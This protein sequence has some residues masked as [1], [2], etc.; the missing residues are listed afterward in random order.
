MR[1]LKTMKKNTK[2]TTKGH[3][4]PFVNMLM[5]ML[6]LNVM[7]KNTKSTT[8]FLKKENNRNIM[9]YEHGT[10]SRCTRNSFIILFGTIGYCK[11][12]FDTVSNDLETKDTIQKL[13]ETYGTN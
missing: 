5:L 10:C 8:R 9:T 3:T 6:Y 7:K 1:T 11:S 12:C 13:R 2:S 4:S